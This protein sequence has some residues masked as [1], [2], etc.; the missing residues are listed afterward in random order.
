MLKLVKFLWSK[1]LD[2]TKAFITAS[3]FSIWF[4]ILCSTLVINADNLSYETKAAIGAIN[5]WR[6]VIVFGVLTL[7][8]SIFSIIKKKMVGTVLFLW[9]F[10]VMGT[11]IA[12]LIS[13]NAGMPWS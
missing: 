3:V 2:I 13:R 6:I 10:W 4:L 8:L 1:K 12:I 5:I 11:I 9:F 7:G